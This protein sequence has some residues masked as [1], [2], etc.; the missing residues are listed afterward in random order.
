MWISNAGISRMWEWGLRLGALPAVEFAVGGKG[1]GI[2]VEFGFVG[3][4]ETRLVEV[5]RKRRRRRKG[6]LK[7]EINIVV[8][9]AV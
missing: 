6:V 8:A 5:A 4:D 3:V 9:F 7:V 1:E 2:S